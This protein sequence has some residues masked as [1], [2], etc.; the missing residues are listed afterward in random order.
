MSIFEHLT[1]HKALPTVLGVVGA[2]IMLSYSPTPPGRRQWFT[3]VVSGSV[4]AY[5][6]PPLI[7]PALK[8]YVSLPWLPVDGSIEG[9]VGL[10]LGLVGVHLVG[11]ILKIAKAFTD[12]P[13]AFAGS[14]F[15][16]FRGPK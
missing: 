15:A 9:L 14:V 10:V 3:G 4:L 2:A 16:R 8:H 1:G 7:V 5:L 13:V 11:G 12:D 6:G